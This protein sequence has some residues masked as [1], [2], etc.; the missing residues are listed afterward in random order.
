MKLLIIKVFVLFIRVLYAPM[1]MRRKQ[2]K[3]LDG[4]TMVIMPANSER[5]QTKYSEI[6]SGSNQKASNFSEWLDFLFS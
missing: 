6:D 3:M 5:A 4:E 1:K 2:N